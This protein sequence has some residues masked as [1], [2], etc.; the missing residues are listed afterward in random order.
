[1][2]FQPAKMTLPVVMGATFE[3]YGAAMSIPRWPSW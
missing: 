2:L 3:P 1:L